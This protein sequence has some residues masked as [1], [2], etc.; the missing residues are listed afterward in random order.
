[1]LIIGSLM[2]AGEKLKEHTFWKSFSERVFRSYN[3]LTGGVESL[4]KAV[5]VNS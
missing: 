5:L 3:P 1:M 2:R 4:N